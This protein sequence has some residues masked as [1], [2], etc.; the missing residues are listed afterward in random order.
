MSLPDGTCHQA[1]PHADCGKEVVL[2]RKEVEMVPVFAL[3]LSDADPGPVAGC[4]RLTTVSQHLHI[5][6]IDP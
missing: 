1:L 5:P 4:E 6:T 2:A 3:M